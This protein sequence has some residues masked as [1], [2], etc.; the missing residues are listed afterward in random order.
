M[1]FEELT[2]K[3]LLT[4]AGQF[5][6]DSVKEN[7][8]KDTLANELRENGVTEDFVEDN[9]NLVK[10][11]EELQQNEPSV[12]E[13]E[14]DDSPTILMRMTRKNP[15]FEVLGYRFSQD[16]PFRPVREKDVDKIMDLWD[17]FRTATPREAA[18]FYG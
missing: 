2:K 7:M 16:H 10:R 1:K 18:E 14:E 5:G 9:L 4:I 12:E 13:E 8:N 3:E 15:T 6:I 11:E 17:G